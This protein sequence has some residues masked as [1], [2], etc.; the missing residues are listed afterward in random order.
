[1]VLF[2]ELCIRAMCYSVLWVMR[3]GLG[4]AP[5]SSFQVCTFQVCTKLGKCCFMPGKR[6]KK[7][8]VPKT[9]LKARALKQ[10]VFFLA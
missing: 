2:R 3:V 8:A 10:N 5:T 7:C 1:M 6:Y 4:M 9:M